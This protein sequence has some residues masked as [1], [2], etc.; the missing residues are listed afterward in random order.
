MKHIMLEIS[1]N[2]PAKTPLFHQSYRVNKDLSFL[3]FCDLTEQE[4]LEVL[5]WRNHPQVRRC[6]YRSTPISEKEHFD[7]LANLPMQNKRFYWVVKEGGKSLGVV[8][9]VDYKISGSEW[10]FYLN[11]AHFGDGV[12]VNLVYHALNFFFLKLGLKRLYGYCH[13]KNTKALLF[14]DLFRIEHTNYEKLNVHSTADWYSKR[15]IEAENWI[16]QNCTIESLRNRKL[17]LSKFNKLE[18]KKLTLDQIFLEIFDLSP[19]L[20]RPKGITMKPYQK[21][22]LRRRTKQTFEVDI[23][24]LKSENPIQFYEILRYCV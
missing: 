10:G 13:Y 18:A 23:P 12:S 7:F 2:T 4:A 5:A 20:F 22:E 21:I 6:M 17:A 16:G 15:V 11:P 8:D 9:I 1:I 19:S 3:N 14:H 24:S